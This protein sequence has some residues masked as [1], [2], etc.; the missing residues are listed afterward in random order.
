MSDKDR[1]AALLA[2]I[3]ERQRQARLLSEIGAEFGSHIMVR[4]VV[5]VWLFEAAA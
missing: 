3:H 1:R 2:N 5:L 4:S